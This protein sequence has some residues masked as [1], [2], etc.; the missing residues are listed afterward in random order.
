MMVETIEVADKRS[1]KIGPR[2][3]YAPPNLFR[4]E[5]GTIFMLPLSLS[6]RRPK[7]E[8]DDGST[9]RERRKDYNEDSRM[10]DA[11]PPG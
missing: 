7:A 3:H 10:N 8:A 9:I 6:R 4:R 1:Q 2:I 11:P 5:C